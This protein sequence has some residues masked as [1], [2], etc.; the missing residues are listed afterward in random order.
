[1]EG[2]QVIFDE[3]WDVK[4]TVAQNEAFWADKGYAKSITLLK[5]I[6]AN[7]CVVEF[8]MEAPGVLVCRI[9]D[10]NVTVNLLDPSGLT[11]RRGEPY[12]INN[13]PC[14]EHTSINDMF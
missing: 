8:D 13:K 6:S 1:M 4:T 12:L 3:G 9:P 10:H 5:S 14:L 11:S 7:Q 2:S